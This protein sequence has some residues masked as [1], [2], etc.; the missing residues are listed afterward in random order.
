L[1][2]PHL[3]IYHQEPELRRSPFYSL[4]NTHNKKLGHFKEIQFTAKEWRMIDE[5]NKELEVRGKLLNFLLCFLGVPCVQACT[6]SPK[7]T[8]Q[9][10]SVTPYYRL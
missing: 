5:L 10:L 1:Y 2:I 8:P 3:T 4:Q 6:P 7:G 9:T